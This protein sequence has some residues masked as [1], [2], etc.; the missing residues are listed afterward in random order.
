MFNSKCTGVLPLKIMQKWFAEC[1]GDLQC[2]TEHH[3]KQKEDNHLRLAEQ[4]KCIKTKCIHQR[5]S[6]CSTRWRALRHRKRV[7]A[8][9]KS[10][11]CSE[12]KLIWAFCPS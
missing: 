5:T 6:S 10:C 7:D 1:I 2:S 9:K 8:H 11:S 4:N 12:Q 3:R